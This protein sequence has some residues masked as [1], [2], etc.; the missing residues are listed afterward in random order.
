MS[1]RF[2]SQAHW[3]TFRCMTRQAFR[4]IGLFIPD[5]ILVRV[6]TGDAADARIGAVEAL[7]V[8]QTVRLKADVDWTPPI[9]SHNRFPR[10]MATPAE[11]RDVF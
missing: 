10:A 4:V 7:A 11:V 6:M 2:G 5:Q 1:P 8:G 3:P 9:A